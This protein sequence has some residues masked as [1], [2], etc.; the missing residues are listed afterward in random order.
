MAL[1]NENRLVKNLIVGFL[2][3]MAFLFTL[4]ISSSDNQSVL[5]FWKSLGSQIL[6]LIISFLIYQFG[7][8]DNYI[9]GINTKTAGRSLLLGILV[10]GLYI[11]I[12]NLV[13]GFSIAIPLVPASVSDSLKFFIV[14]IVSPIVETIF[15]LG[16]LLGY[17]RSFEPTRQRIFLAVVIQAFLFSLFHLGAY[18]TGIYDYSATQGFLGFTQNISVFISAFIFG[19]ISGY[20]VYLKKIK[21]LLIAMVIHLVIN[22]FAFTKFAIIFA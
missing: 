11:L 13:P 6:F 8:Y 21:S 22:L 7:T 12:S 20:L 16:T 10:G 1:R 15:F 2:I 14:V 3:L 17:I 18:L 5:G 9:L 19:I 4:S